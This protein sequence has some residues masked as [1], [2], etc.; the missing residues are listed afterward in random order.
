MRQGFTEHRVVDVR[1]RVHVNA[2]ERPVTLC[3]RPQNRQDNCVIT[4][5]R[6]RDDVMV[7]S[8]S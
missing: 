5:Q 1:V 4:P 7:S 6:Q 3:E 2:A 8:S